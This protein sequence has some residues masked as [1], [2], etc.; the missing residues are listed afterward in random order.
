MSVWLATTRTAVTER[1]VANL[2]DPKTKLILSYRPTENSY[3]DDSSKP[4]HVGRYPASNTAVT[5]AV[6]AVVRAANEMS[7]CIVPRPAPLLSARYIN[8]CGLNCVELS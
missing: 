3:T 6:K 4:R 1:P 7:G 5:T 2:S 8:N